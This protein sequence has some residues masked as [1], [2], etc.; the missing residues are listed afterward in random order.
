MK[1][2]EQSQS[3]SH[4]ENKY[5]CIFLNWLSIEKKVLITVYNV[6][7]YSQ[8]LTEKI[9]TIIINKTAYLIVF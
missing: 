7:C 5:N 4:N 9:F 1:Y 8:E 3:N 6:K 2:W